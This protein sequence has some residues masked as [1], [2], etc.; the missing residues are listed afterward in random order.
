M[1]RSRNFSGE[2]NS[3]VDVLTFY[4]VKA[5]QLLLRFSEGTIGRQH[6]PIAHAHGRSGTDRMERLSAQHSTAFSDFAT[7]LIVCVHLGLLFGLARRGCRLNPVDQH[8]VA[9]IKN[10]PVFC[11]RRTDCSVSSYL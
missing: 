1:A 6:L 7:E 11:M 10:P 2:L 5:A 4:Q 8:H 3:F 9:N